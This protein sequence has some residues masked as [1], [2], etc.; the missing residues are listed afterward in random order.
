MILSN[1]SYKT[2]KYSL[3]FPNLLL[4]QWE[5]MHI[6][7]YIH[8]CRDIY[9]PMKIKL[10]AIYWA[11]WCAHPL[12]AASKANELEVLCAG[13]QAWLLCLSHSL[14]RFVGPPLY[15]VTSIYQS[16]FARWPA[17]IIFKNLLQG[18]WFD[19]NPEKKCPKCRVTKLLDYLSLEAVRG[20]QFFR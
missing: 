13:L 1:R 15:T 10:T 8:R 5:N 19:Q 16:R 2:C 7:M 6:C 11:F 18:D 20:Q 4:I 17:F 3:K 12:E 14:T 9:E